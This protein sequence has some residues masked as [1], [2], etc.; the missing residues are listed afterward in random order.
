MVSYDIVVRVLVP[1]LL[2]A[3]LRKMEIDNRQS[4]REL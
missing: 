4:R 2:L 3:P 1:F